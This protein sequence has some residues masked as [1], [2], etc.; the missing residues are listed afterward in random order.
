MSCQTRICASPG[1]SVRPGRSLPVPGRGGSFRPV[2]DRV[3]DRH[4]GGRSRVGGGEFFVVAR[5]PGG[6]GGQAPYVQEAPQQLVAGGV[7][8]GIDC[9][10]IL[11][12]KLIAF[13]LGRSRM[14]TC[15]SA[16]S[17]A[18]CAVTS[19][20]LRAPA[21][22]RL[23]AAP[24]KGRRG[25]LAQRNDRWSRYR[26]HSRCGRQPGLPEW[27]GYLRRNG[28]LRGEGRPL[29]AHSCVLCR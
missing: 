12:E 13:S 26:A 11:A 8:S 2:R 3:D 29:S 7:V 15:G 24:A 19:P 18:G 16:G 28:V 10:V 5:L 25:L 17:S 23:P 20:S 14:I 9:L 22:L 1:H 21:V 4:G 27:R 6:D